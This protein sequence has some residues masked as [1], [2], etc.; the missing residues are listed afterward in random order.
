MG[1]SCLNKLR[2]N[3]T[4]ACT[5]PLVGVKNIYLMHTEDVTLTA[6]ADSTVIKSVAFASDNRAILVEGYKQN[7][8]IT[9]A[10]RTMDASARLDFSVMFK[11]VGRD[12]ST[13][14]RVR[15]LLS[16]KFYVLAEYQD[17]SYSFIGYTSPLEC[18]GMD[19]DSNA[20]AGFTT[21]TLAAPEGSAGNYLMGASVDTVATIKSR[22]GV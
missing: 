11:M 21:V 8:Q 4:V 3:I 18:S 2:G 17:S 7:I 15:S 14:L 20:N 6:D 12:A 22:V 10:I 5:I 16:G 19:T 13:I 9:S 1:K